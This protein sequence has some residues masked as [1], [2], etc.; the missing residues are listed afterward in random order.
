MGQGGR[1]QYFGRLIPLTYSHIPQNIG[2]FR[3]GHKKTSDPREGYRKIT[4]LTLVP[5]IFFR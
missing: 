3:G 1:G 4:D 2:L 5:L